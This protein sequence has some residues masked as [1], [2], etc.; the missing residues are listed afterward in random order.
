MLDEPTNH[1]DLNAVLWLDDYMSTWKNT[2]LVVS[3]DQDFLTSVY[4][5]HHVVVF[6]RSL[7]L[8]ACLPRRLGDMVRVEQNFVMLQAG[9]VCVCASVRV[10]VCG[11]VG[12]YVYVWADNT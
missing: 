1:L 4:V 6:D 11:W 10:C 5:S 8:V 3:H 2:L 9:D 7:C 12:V